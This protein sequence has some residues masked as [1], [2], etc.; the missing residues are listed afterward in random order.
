MAILNKNF[1]TVIVQL[2]EPYLIQFTAQ[3]QVLKY[4]EIK[5]TV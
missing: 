4:I 2:Y 3:F 5:R 1:E